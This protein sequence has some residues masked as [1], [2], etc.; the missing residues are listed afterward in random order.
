MRYLLFLLVLLAFSCNKEDN[1]SGR[2]N[3]DCEYL[4]SPGLAIQPMTNSILVNY[5]FSNIAN[6]P[7]DPQPAEE[8]SC[9][10]EMATIS[11]SSDGENFEEVVTLGAITGTY[12][13]ED[14]EDCELIHVRLQG[15][16]QDFETVSTTRTA[17][18]GAVSYTHLTLPTICSV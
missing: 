14:L 17:I 2:S 6:W 18:V 7:I 10:P 9:E 1:S 15:S 13:I 16:H 11:I 3:G 4:H 12:L 5:S 8:L